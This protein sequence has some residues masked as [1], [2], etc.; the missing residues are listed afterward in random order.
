MIV[1]LCTAE[2]NYNILFTSTPFLL[3]AEGGYFN[4]W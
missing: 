2:K 1:E 3:F 4:S